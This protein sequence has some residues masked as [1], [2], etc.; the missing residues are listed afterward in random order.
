MQ[1]PALCNVCKQSRPARDCTVC[2]GCGAYELS[3]RQYLMHLG[4][5]TSQ[6]A[7]VFPI[8]DYIVEHVPLPATPYG[9][10][11]LPL[12]D[13][14]FP[15]ASIGETI[16]TNPYAQSGLVATSDGVVRPD[17]VQDR[18]A[19]SNRELE[20]ELYATGGVRTRYYPG[21]SGNATSILASFARF[22]FPAQN[23][24]LIALH[25]LE[26]TEAGLLKWRA[27]KTGFP[28][29]VYYPNFGVGLVTHHILMKQ[30]TPPGSG[31]PLASLIDGKPTHYLAVH[32]VTPYG[33]TPGEKFGL[34]FWAVPAVMTRRMELAVIQML[35]YEGWVQAVDSKGRQYP[36]AYDQ[37]MNSKDPRYVI[38]RRAV[39]LQYPSVSPS[40]SF[41]LLN[42]VP[43]D[44]AP[45]PV[46]VPS[47]WRTLPSAGVSQTTQQQQQDQEE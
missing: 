31:L 32:K 25:P 27:L 17:S 21:A 44:M 19:P 3:R 29:F 47:L 28:V 24:R 41:R 45:N 46:V 35:P 33:I 40:M 36:I 13:G 34:G 30:G 43:P 37:F 7:Y 14:T 8:D 5:D 26:I 20:Q 23:R 18:D 38:A 2:V 10:I 1:R 6:K 22:L 39:Q 15:P 12:W 4:S 9:E 11:D 16:V 42:E